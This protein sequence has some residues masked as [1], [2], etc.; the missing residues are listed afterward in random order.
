[1]SLDNFAG[2]GVRQVVAE[3]ADLASYSARVHDDG[4]WELRKLGTTVASG[5]VFLFEPSE[6]HTLEVEA[7]ENVITVRLDGRQLTSY[8]DTAAN[9]TMSGRISVL[10]GYANT[11]FDDLAVTPIEGLSWEATRI[12]DADSRISYPQGSSFTQAGYAHLNRTQHVLAAG[13]SAQFTITGTGFNL[14]GATGTATLDIRVDNDP[15]R[16]TSVGP[17]GNR[18]TSYWLR[19]LTDGEHTVTVTVKTGTFVLDGVDAVHGGADAGPVD[20]EDRPIAQIGT[21]PRLTGIVGQDPELPK[22]VQATSEAGGTIDAP[23]T[24][25]TTPG[26]FADAYALVPVSGVFTNNPSLAVTTQ[27]EVIPDGV[28]YLVD[29]NAPADG[30]AYPVIAAAAEDTILND[31][32]D[33]VFTEESGWGRVGTATGKGRLGQS[34]YDKLRETGWYSGSSSTPLEYRF[35]LAAGDYQLSTGHTEWWN[36]GPGRSRVVTTTVEATAADGSKTSVP[37][38]SHS[39]A[40]G[41]IGTSAVLT[42]ALSLEQDS[43]VRVLISGTGGTEAPALSWIGIAD[44]SVVIDKSA[45]AEQLER[46]QDRTKRAYTAESWEQLRQAGLTARDVNDNGS[47]S[48]GEVDEATAALAAAIDGLVEVA[49]I[50]LDD[51][52]QAVL[53]S[54]PVTLPETIALTTISGAE[55]QVEVTWQNTPENLE[56]YATTTVDG[57]AGGTTV[58]M[59]LEALPDDV[60][61]FVDA[62]AVEGDNDGNA[63]ITSP[64]HAAVAQLRGD[65][66]LNEQ[67]DAPFSEDTGWGLLNPIDEGDGFV[68]A[69]SRVSGDYDKARTTGWWASSGG[70][71]D[72]RLTLPAGEWELDSGYREWWGQSRQVQPSVTVGDTVIDGDVV[73]LSGSTPDGRSTIA[74]ELEEETTVTFRAA[75]ASGSADPVLSWLAVSGEEDAGPGEP[76]EPELP[77]DSA[78]AAPGRGVL[79]TT[80]GWAD[81]RHDGNFTLTMNLWWGEN[82]TRMKLYQDGELISTVP[83]EWATPAAQKATVPITGLANGTYEFTAELIN[84]RGTTATTAVSVRVT[85]AAPGQPVLSHDNWSGGRDFTVTANLWWGTNATSYRF[86]QNGELIGEGDVAAASPA[87]QRVQVPVSVTAAGQYE[88]TVDFVTER[89]HT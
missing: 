76:E 28:R 84:S 19:G 9:P 54:G 60:V 37:I 33:R 88:Y 68:G 52:R 48:Q 87:A 40:N 5:T 56:P 71:V 41:S 34:P 21:L 89:G 61:Y 50:A 64:A 53:S 15:V 82:A 23:V 63:G 35:T 55:Q 1:S 4:R 12:D 26:M 65:A 57:L 14:I 22:T 32:A 47:A 25:Q 20:P 45:L 11:Q 2:L 36:P 8:A 17:V 29:A 80:S 69:K 42:G 46:A 39:F 7:R 67:A 10:S 6:W 49:Y 78:T 3:G 81:G 73:R 38:G 18:Q 85:D 16:T 72:Y 70:S 43:V 86:F 83:L 66:L 27:V 59:V 74:F 31:S 79:S 58:S 44:Q 77:E 30:A 62:A 75:K 24:W 51:Y 13:R